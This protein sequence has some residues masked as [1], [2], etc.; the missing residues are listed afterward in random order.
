MTAPTPADERPVGIAPPPSPRAYRRRI[1]TE[2]WIVLGLSLGRSGLYAVVNIIDRLTAGPP[3]A[4]QS[5]TLNP[6]R[7]DRPWL[8]L[9]YQLLQIGFA[10]VPVALA[11]YLLSANGRSAVRRIGLDL[12]RP[13][14]DLGIGVA[15]AAAL[16]I[17]GLGLYAAA[18]A[19]GLA[20]EVQ[21][22]ALNAAWWTI[23]VLI[24][25]ALQNALVEEVIV[26]GYLMERLREL[27]W[28][29][30]AILVTSALLRGSYHLYQGWGAFVGNA[31]MG[32]VFAEY[33]RRKRRVMPLVMAH[34]VM[35]V[36]VFV[37]YALVPDEWI[38]ALGL[39]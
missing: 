39:D 1:T 33:Y 15:L 16:G 14:R 9:T 19:L 28:S 36:V 31:I 38:A 35:D 17:P 22:S 10:L 8:D 18:R 23:P 4:D 29:T 12:T 26:V 6:S 25:A 13:W 21:A 34:T 30:P 11:L 7:S 20:V 2:I 5:T 37:G 3:L 27:R 32:L 24:L